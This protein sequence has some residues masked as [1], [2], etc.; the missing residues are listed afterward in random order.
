VKKN[1][2]LSWLFTKI[3]FVDFFETMHMGFSSVKHSLSSSVK[4][5]KFCYFNLQMSIVHTSAQN[6]SCSLHREFCALKWKI[7]STYV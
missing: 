6:R 7:T 2:A 1:C 4:L 5:Y 3:Q